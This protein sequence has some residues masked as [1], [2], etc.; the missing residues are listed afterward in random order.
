MTTFRRLLWERDGGRCGICMTDVDVNAF[1]I[2][3]IEPVANGGPNTWGNLQPAHQRCNIR[4]NAAS[5]S[6]LGDATPLVAVPAQTTHAWLT[7]DEAA[8]LLRVKRITI[9]RWLQSGKLYGTQPLSK[10]A[11]WRIPS[12]EVERLLGH[13]GDAEPAAAE[14]V[15]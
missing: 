10:R 6:L 12:S 11:G 1:H 3:H 14:R 8:E 13:G 15:E 5:V 2:D 7:T 9:Q 4:K